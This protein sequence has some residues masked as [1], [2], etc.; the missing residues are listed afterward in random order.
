MEILII[1]GVLVLVMVIVSTQIKK[2][3]ERAFEPEIVETEDFRLVKPEG[4]VHP[5]RDDSGYA[6]EAYSKDYGERGERNIWRAQVYLTVSANLDFVSACKNVR[7][8]ADKVLAEN[9]LQAAP[10]GEKMCLIES[11]KSE[12]EVNFYEIRK[13]IESK[14]QQ[15]TYDLQILV[16]KAF[17]DNYVGRID[18]LINSFRLK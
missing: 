13:I 12:R 11:E 4:F 16:L 18:E 14:K 17:R 6:F 7:Q 15:K 2:S 9:I 1:G 3:A 8:E 5:I 10:E